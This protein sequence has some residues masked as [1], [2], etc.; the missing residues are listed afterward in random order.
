M[1]EVTPTMARGTTL[2]SVALILL[3]IPPSLTASPADPG[4]PA[5][6][7]AEMRILLVYGDLVGGETVTKSAS[8]HAP[9]AENRSRPVDPW[10]SYDKV[11]HFSFSLLITVG[12]QYAFVNKLSWSERSALP[13]SMVTSA[14]VG[15]AKE[16]YDWQYGPRRY[17]SQRDMIANFAGIL[18]AAGFILL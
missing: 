8:L 16:I 15:L 5:L 17:F 12:S 11:Q 18:V 3:L 4:R 13:A 10:F 6:S 14:S 2:A 9:Y 7:P 1:K